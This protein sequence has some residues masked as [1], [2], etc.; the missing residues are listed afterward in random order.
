M[1]SIGAALTLVAS[2]TVILAPRRFAVMGI[3]AGVCYITQGQVLDVGGFHF[4]A[5]RIILFSGFIRILMRSE[6]QRIRL[7]KID[8][9]VLAYTICAALVSI[10]RT[11]LWQ[12]QVGITYNITLSYLVCRCLVTDWSDFQALLPS[13]ALLIAPLALCMVAESLTRHNVFDFMGGH[14]PSD[15]DG[16]PRCTGA[17]RGPHTAGTF[18]A[19]LMPLFAGIFF[20]PGK[21]S[22]SVIGFVAATAITY[23]SNSS[24]PL[25]AYLSCII[26]LTF[27]PLRQDM[28][29][30]RR[31]IVFALVAYTLVSKAP[32]WYVFSKVS[33]LTGGDG[34][35]RSYL[36]DQCFKHISDWWLSGTED[37][38]AW[39]VTHMAW[40]GADITN[41]Y[42][43]NA[44]NAGLGGLLLFILILVRSF[45][46]LGLTLKVLRNVSP[47]TE[48]LL[49]CVSCALLG[50]VVTLFSVTYFDQMHVIWWGFLAMIASVTGDIQKFVKEDKPIEVSNPFGQC[51]SENSVKSPLL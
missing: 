7:S 23:T 6:L 35:H 16:R 13:L 50:H 3:F 20:V 2:L 46:N 31:G 29:K 38:S 19:T 11:G 21:R 5:I 27:W 48:W 33:D 39:A 45:Q 43:S 8:W 25:M 44:A 42:V 32:V 15:R 49:W 9:A 51:E 34:W 4:Y 30:V 24:G 47:H 18:G 36:M 37:T 1:N 17:F 40:G 22:A 26:A 28:R 12:E 10:S 14:S 41:E